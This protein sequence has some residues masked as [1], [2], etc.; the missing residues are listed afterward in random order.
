MLRSS[1]HFPLEGRPLCRLFAISTVRLRTGLV[2]HSLPRGAAAGNDATLLMPYAALLYE[3]TRLQIAFI[4]DR[5]WTSSLLGS[6]SSE[7]NLLL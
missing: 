4:L 7:C 6:G 5:E 3:D 2:S 1:T